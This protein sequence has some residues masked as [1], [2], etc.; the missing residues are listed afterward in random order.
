MALERRMAP[1]G[2]ARRRPEHARHGRQVNSQR[3]LFDGSAVAQI[4]ASAAPRIVTFES[5]YDGAWREGY[6]MSPMKVP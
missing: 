2:A 1:R 3:Y 5:G 4:A 6:S